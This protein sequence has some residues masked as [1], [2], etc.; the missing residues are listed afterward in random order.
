MSVCLRMKLRAVRWLGQLGRGSMRGA[1]AWS[2]QE[3]ETL[4]CYYVLS[5]CNHMCVCINCL[6]V[7]VWIYS[8]VSPIWARVYGTCLLAVK[9]A[10]V[11][12]VALSV[13][14]LWTLTCVEFFFL[15]FL[16][17]SVISHEIITTALLL[18]IVALPAVG[19]FGAAHKV[20]T[21]D[22]PVQW[23]A[24]TQ[25]V[26]DVS[27]WS[28]LWSLFISLLLRNTIVL[29]RSTELLP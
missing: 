20:W 19:C 22:L 29:L 26:F 24:L 5:H 8:C 18:L 16:A 17:N 10:C 25:P 11:P 14:W 2:K 1:G 15:H 13:C 27:C 4:G 3:R 12:I 28:D 7:P 6:V 9:C 23:T 21:S